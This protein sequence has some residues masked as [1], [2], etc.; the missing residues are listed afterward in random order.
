MARALSSPDSLGRSLDARGI[1]RAAPLRREVL[2]VQGYGSLS[3]SPP[4]VVDAPY[5]FP[6]R[7]IVIS[8][9]LQD[10]LRDKFGSNAE[11]VVTPVDLDLFRPI[12]VAVTTSRPRR[13]DI[14]DLAAKLERLDVDATLRAQIAAAGARFVRT[15]FSWDQAVRRLERLFEDARM[16]AG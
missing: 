11:V 6:L 1:R 4:E 7:K 3:Y 14:G 16:Q 9:W 13:R 2:L 12:P 5:G 15:A 8:T 10:I